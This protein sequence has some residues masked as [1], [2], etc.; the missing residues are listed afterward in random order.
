MIMDDIRF[1]SISEALLDLRQ[2]K[3]VIVVDGEDREN[4]GDFIGA[5]E[6]C[7]PEMI[8]F[9]ATHGR[10]LICVAINGERV[11]ALH[12]PMMVE[13]EKNNALHK[14][15]FTVSVDYSLG[16]TTGISAA[17]RAKTVA[18][19]ADPDVP[20]DHFARP[21]HI[22][23]LRAVVGGL[24]RRLGHTEAGVDLARLAGLHP[25]AVLVEILNHDGTMARVPDLAKVAKQFDLKIITIQDLLAYR[26]LRESRVER[27]VTV[28]LPTR[29]GNFDLVAFRDVLTGDGHLALTKGAWT[30]DEPVLVRMHS[31]CMTGDVFGSLRCDCGDQIQAALQM[32]EREG[33][34]VL[35][36]LKEEG[37]G[38]GLL[39]KL[40]AYRL[41]EVGFD[42]VQA[43]V[44][45][46]FDPDS[47][48][49]N[50]ACH[51]LHALELRRVRLLTN[52]PVKL[53]CVQLSGVE[54]VE[55]IS[56]PM[57]VHGH[58]R[59]YLKTKRDKM[60]HFSDLLLSDRLVPN[61]D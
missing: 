57:Q 46:G 28:D 30:V 52:N 25:T 36:Y 23:P 44:A 61:W 39:N 42:T 33:K 34:G 6:K 38:I 9:M 59:L 51:M 32:I 17:D 1:N 55:Q 43:N 40:K 45:L 19:L 24:F 4:E 8:N 31:E 20:E 49:Y 58:N 60:G 11:A 48:D 41:Q 13:Y 35:L 54:V 26:L 47:R 18:A 15:A 53:A 5:A 21:G 12:L 14:T 16:T 22:F 37:R 2:G 56:M 29:W 7:T 3:L 27:V 10:G 50:V